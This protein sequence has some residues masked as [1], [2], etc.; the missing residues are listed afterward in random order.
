M[1]IP[2]YII[3]RRNKLT[4][5]FS[6]KIINTKNDLL[7]GMT[8]ALALVPE[9]IAF[10]FIA[11]VQPLVGLYAAFIIG[12]ITATFGG[13]PG[14]ISGATGAL[15]VVM[16]SLVANH[17][18]QYLFAT[19]I[20][21]GILQMIFATFKLGKFI[22]LVPH[23]VML[24]F[25]NGLA[26]V[27]FLAQL[28]Q[29]GYANAEGWLHGSLLEGS[30][31]DVAWLAA[32]QLYALL[33]LVAT[34][35]A[36]IYLLPKLTKTVPSSLA[37]IVIV[38]GLVTIFN[39]DTKTVGDIAKIGGGL[40]TFFVPKI[41]F[42]LKTLYIIFP[43]S[44]ILAMI[45]II[46]SLLTLRMID[47]ITETHGSSNRECFAQGAAN[48]VTGFFGGMGGCAMIGQSMINVN[49]GGKTR[50]SGI[51]AALFLLTFILFAAPLIEQIPI[52]AL[53]GVM[54]SVVIGTF[55]W[56]SLRIFHKI[57]K[58]DAFVLILVSL[59]TVITD[60]ATA[61]IL[62]VIVSALIFAWEHAKSI[63]VVKQDD[64]K[65][66]TLYKVSGP[67]FFGS[68]SIFLQQFK[69]RESLNDIIIDFANSQV[70]D[71]SGLEAIYTLA[72]RYL[73]AGKTLHL[74]HLSADCRKLLKKAGNIVEVNVIEDPKYFVAT[75]A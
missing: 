35:L 14:M 53:V 8:V 15:A 72:E 20:L 19:V 31:I 28:K 25:V 3:I 64:Y 44:L 63:M 43:Y 13:R 32:P 68:I 11:G 60:L 36:I 9:A 10:A 50:I 66:S 34:T 41:P 57:P 45:G 74:I 27:I 51:S 2:N 12:I 73:N 39:I 23:P 42:S 30:V 33:L 46:E 6:N 55:E 48:V 1:Y 24:G 7:A 47:E 5:N 71:H 61:V 38:S 70:C 67:L 54:F 52:A 16:V 21:M 59:V 29:F 22:R 65:G 62:G 75:N 17:G 40:P 56:S 26:I 58:G 4:N 69:I 18:V 37:A 49:S